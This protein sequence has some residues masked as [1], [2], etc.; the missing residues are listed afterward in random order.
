[1]VHGNT[2]KIDDLKFGCKL[3]N[4]NKLDIQE[5]LKRLDDMD[6]TADKVAS[7]FIQV[8]KKIYQK[9]RRHR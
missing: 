5:A 1:L 6:R 2:R 8:L 4:T 3:C 9:I 7:G